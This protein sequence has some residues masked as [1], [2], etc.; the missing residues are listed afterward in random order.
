MSELPR[1]I[2][3]AES[4]AT[5]AKAAMDDFVV[6]LSNV[7]NDIAR[8]EQELADKRRVADTEIA[9]L[10]ASIDERKRELASVELE[11]RQVRRDLERERKEVGLEK[12]R[13]IR[14]LDEVMA[15]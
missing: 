5:A 12:Q 11:L 14:S 2:V 1:L 10:R 4:K 7:R 8:C 9:K 15:R 6:W 13:L 3:D